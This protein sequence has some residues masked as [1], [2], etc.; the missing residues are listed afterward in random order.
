MPATRRRDL[1]RDRRLVGLL[2][3]DVVSLT[4][5]QM[6]WVALPWFVLTTSGS[7]TR[8]TAVLAMQAAAVAV[9]GL[10][11][12]GVAT[13]AGPRRTM[14]VCDAARAPILAAIPL[15]HLAGALSF[16]VLLALVAAMGTLMTPSFASKAALLPDLVGDDE[17]A[18]AEANALLQMA[19][20][21]AAI[22]GPPV[23]GVLIGVIGATSVLL[24]DA[25]TFAAGFA[26][27]A[28]LVRV[29]GA[30]AP[31]QDETR[32]L[33]AGFRF[34][35][36]D[37]LLRGWS[38][39]LILGD[40]VWLALFAAIPVLVVT[41]FGEQ[42]ELVGWI[43]AGFGFGAV[44]GSVIALRIVRSVDRLLLASVGELGMAAPLWVFVFH[45][46]APVLVAAMGAAGLANGLV[47][48]PAHTI[49]MLRTPARLRTKL[50]SAIITAVAVL[51]PVA[52]LATGPSLERFGVDPT[53]AVLVAIDSVAVLLFAWTGLRHR[54]AV[55]TRAA[56]SR[57]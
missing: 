17:S 16:G 43:F 40:V 45:V 56:A 54:A 28:V 51:S 34:L 49:V 36:G 24:V 35:V 3:R 6:T 20:R 14:L 10:A 29:P 41:R 1:L 15:L 48:A 32:G 57:A 21:T 31:E 37:S 38:A 22:A 25:L 8:M 46:P 5:S 42:P 4:G 7:A 53:V 11:L 52:L 2:L 26:L 19:N 23:A 13:H 30:P 18:L 33:A 9:G 50:F 44:L 55:A 39:A 27:I 12:G 47:N